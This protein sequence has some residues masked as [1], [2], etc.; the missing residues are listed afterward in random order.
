MTRVGAGASAR[1]RGPIGV[2][3]CVVRAHVRPSGRPVMKAPRC[4]K[5]PGSSCSGSACTIAV[6]GGGTIFRPVVPVRVPAWTPAIRRAQLGGRPALRMPHRVGPSRRGPA[7]LRAPVAAWCRMRV[8]WPRLRPVRRRWS[9]ACNGVDLRARSSG[10]LPAERPT[11]R[12][13]KFRHLQTEG[14]A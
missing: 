9:A 7:R 13:A 6:T 14:S 10:G 12:K 11:A 3:L 2:R 5:A 8:H 4:R 1:P